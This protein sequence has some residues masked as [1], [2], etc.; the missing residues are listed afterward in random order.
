MPVSPPQLFLENNSFIIA[1]VCGC[2]TLLTDRATHMSHKSFAGLQK[3]TQL[4]TGPQGLDF[5]R[6]ENGVG[7]GEG[8]VG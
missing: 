3:A 5:H 4:C 6:Q 8:C 7:G 2:V 1:G